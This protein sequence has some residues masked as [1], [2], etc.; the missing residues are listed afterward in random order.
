MD[1]ID[2]AGFALW[3]WGIA[4]AWRFLAPVLRDLDQLDGR[5]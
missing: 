3:F 4:L 1:T 5:D 2:M